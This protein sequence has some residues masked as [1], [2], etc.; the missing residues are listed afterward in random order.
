MTNGITVYQ[1][2]ASL[3]MAGVKTWETRGNPP[4]GDMRPEGVRG[5]PG[6]RVNAG[7]RVAIHAAA[8]PVRTLPTE[9]ITSAWMPGSFDQPWSWGDE[10]VD[11]LGRDREAQDALEADIAKHGIRE[12]AQPRRCD[13]A[14]LVACLRVGH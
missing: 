5:L 11:I 2:H 14:G 7:D 12:G 1:P 4:H 8:K 13:V 3:I 9:M 10:I 6:R